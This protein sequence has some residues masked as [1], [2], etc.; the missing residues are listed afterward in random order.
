MRYIYACISS[1][2][3]RPMEE[4]MKTRKYQK[5]VKLAKTLRIDNVVID[6][7]STWNREKSKLEDI[8]AVPGNVIVVT[9]ISCLGQKAEISNVYSR[10]AESGNEL[11]IAYY[12]HNGCL[13]ADPKSTV[14]LSFD[15]KSNVDISANIE[16]LSNMSTSDYR[17]SA[18]SE[19]T[20]AFVNGYWKIERGEASEQEVLKE[21]NMSRTSFNTRLATYVQSDG[22]WAQFE[23]E[24]DSGLALQPTRLGRIS[25]DAMKLYNY[26]Q[27]AQFEKEDEGTIEIS[28]F[29][30]GIE[31]EMWEKGQ[32]CEGQQALTEEQAFWSNRYFL[33]AMHLYREVLRY[34]KHLEY[35]KYRKYKNAST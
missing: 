32:L 4:V 10:I 34:R 15:K 20:P 18:L 31:P 14:T 17:S 9:D 3:M 28:A 29:Q 23:K 24:C 30:A 7:C 25:D 12:N 11:L 27:N 33:N 19:I 26:L 6:I 5:A 13:E 35:E 8:L 1:K 22:W 2:S 16:L 21:L